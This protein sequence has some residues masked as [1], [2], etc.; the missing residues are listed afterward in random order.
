MPPLHPVW[1]PDS[2]DI[3][4]PPHEYGFIGGAA[5]V[6]RDNVYFIGSIERH[7]DFH[8]IDAAIRAEGYT[9]VSLSDGPLTDLGRIIF[10][11]KS[12]N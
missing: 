10:I 8:K 12:V 6:F 7:R 9:P 3:L 2:G 4:L 11:D 5:G 1:L